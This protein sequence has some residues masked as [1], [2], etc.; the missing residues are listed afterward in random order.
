MAFAA[1]AIALQTLRQTNLAS[2]PGE[3][4]RRTARE[5]AR[6][7]EG[8]ESFDDVLRTERLW[9]RRSFGPIHRLAGLLSWRSLQQAYDKSRVEWQGTVAGTRTLILQLAARAYEVDHGRKPARAED[10]VP[11][12]L[13]ALPEDPTTGQA[14]ALPSGSTAE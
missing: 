8:R 2:I 7:D 10:L 3:T 1:E 13:D 6:L 5:L 12:Y 14:L 11:N 4:A 9:A